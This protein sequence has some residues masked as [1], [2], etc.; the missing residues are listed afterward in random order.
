[1]AEPTRIPINAKRDHL[2]ALANVRSP[3]TSLTEL[4]WNAFD[5]DANNV[6]VAFE[7][8]ALDALEK[9]R[10]ADDGTG[11]PRSE[12]EIAFG[13]LGGSWKATAR[14]T[15]NKARN[16]HGKTGKGRF[17][18]FGIGGIVLWKT[19]YQDGKDAKEYTI[20]GALDSIDSFAIT[21]EQPT[22][23]PTGTEVVISGITENF[24]SL[25]NHDAP[26]RIAEEFALY[27]LE[28]PTVT[29]TYNGQKVD[30]NDAIA[31]R[32]DF[33]IADVEITP[34][35]KVSSVLTIIEWGAS[36]SRTLYL[37]NSHGIAMHQISPRIHA[38]GFNFTAYLKSDY[39]EELNKDGL[40]LFSGEEDMHSGLEKVLNAAKAELRTYFKGRAAENTA[41]LVQEWKEQNIYPYQGDPTSEVETA[42]RQVFDIVAV[43]VN[44][45]LADFEDASDKSKKFTFNLLKQSLR[46]NPES[47][48][49]IFQDVLN[50]PK[51]TQDDLAELLKQTTLP[52]IITATQK[53]ADRLNFLKGLET[54]VYEPESKKVLKER[55]Q[56]HKILAAETWIFGEEFHL[57]N[58]DESL[59]TVL[60]KY[61]AKLG[62][63]LEDT[64]DVTRAD[65]K[66]AIVD[67]MLARLIPQAR[68]E[69]RDHL[70]IELKRPSVKIGLEELG[71]IESYAFAVANDERFRDTKTRWT[72]WV[73]SN[74]MDDAARRRTRTKGLPDGCIF[75]DSEQPIT[76]WATTWSQILEK[77]R[78]RLEFFRKHLEFDANDESGRAYIQKVHGKYIPEHLKASPKKP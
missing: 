17:R 21:E 6:A 47:L 66:D 69:E 25:L 18:A 23:N 48:Q 46:E 39:L 22:T 78:A 14:T 15:L 10:V 61:Y 71:Q 34:E 32:S 68:A 29:L 74:D 52:A 37:C 20:S 55:K 56:L 19:C 41:A 77:S 45:Y 33:T 5:A 16:L 28:Y 57:T 58:S 35:K 54:L 3:F 38:P 60:K 72:F 51:E 4:I 73:V 49:K 76:I 62:R 27:L 31:R 44:E 67:L 64:T 8:N 42:E 30:P 65:G 36:Q 40:L 50:L 12:A 63:E 75:Q 43:S 2:Q 1:M 9:V 11:I 24:V 59:T 13:S 53:V 26:K 70:V 7:L